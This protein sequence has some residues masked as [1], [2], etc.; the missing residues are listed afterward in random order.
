MLALAT[1]LSISIRMTRRHIV[2]EGTSFSSMTM[3]QFFNEI[4]PLFSCDS[5]VTILP[6]A[7]A[8]GMHNMGAKW[9]RH[10]ACCKHRRTDSAALWPDRGLFGGGEILMVVVR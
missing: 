6:S 1:V 9:L 3:H 10:V 5:V 8:H 4:V 7:H 2:K